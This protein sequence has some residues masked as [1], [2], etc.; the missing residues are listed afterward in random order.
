[1]EK[2]LISL[3]ERLFRIISRHYNN[4]FL[5]ENHLSLGDCLNASSVFSVDAVDPHGGFVRCNLNF[6]GLS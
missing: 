4:K 1:M 2:F 5:I 6:R 3:T